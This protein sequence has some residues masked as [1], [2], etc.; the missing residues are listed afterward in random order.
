MFQVFLSRKLVEFRDIKFESAVVL[1]I[2][3]RSALALTFDAPNSPVGN[4]PLDSST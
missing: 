2:S 1:T 4:G 3:H